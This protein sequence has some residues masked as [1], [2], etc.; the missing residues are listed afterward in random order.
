[1]LFVA[2]TPRRLRVGAIVAGC[3][4]LV[5]P[6]VLELAGVFPPSIRVGQDELTLLA[7]LTYFNE[8]VAVLVLLGVSLLGV[9]SPALLAGRMRDQLLGAERELLFQRW[10]L[11][12]LLPRDQSQALS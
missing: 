11:A 3:L 7:R 1:M 5:L 2:Q 8:G 6:L 12:Q 10:Q 9:V 4:T